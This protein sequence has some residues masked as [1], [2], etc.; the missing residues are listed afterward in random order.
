[1]TLAVDTPAVLLLAPLALLPALVLPFAAADHPSLT[2]VP[3]DRV[4]L[5]VDAGL[6]LV[7][8][9]ALA[10]LVLALAGLHRLAGSVEREGR[11]A[12]IVLLLDRSASMDNSF[13]GRRPGGDEESKSA[14]ARR[15]LL[16]F[17]E[18]RPHDRIG[19]AAFSTAPMPVLPVT[20]HHEALRAAVHA[21]D[22]PGLAHTDVGRGLALAFSMAEGATP[23]SAP[24][25]VLVSDGAAVI[26]RRVQD[27]LRD[28]AA[29]TPVHLYWLYLR[30]QGSRGIFGEPQQPGEDTPQA[31]PERHLHR[32]LGTLGIPYRAFEATGALAV[33][34]AIEAI[35]TLETRPIRYREPVPRRDL[36]GPAYATAAAG[37]LLLLLA[38]LAERRPRRAARP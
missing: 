12:E 37:V 8:V 23:G 30:T 34:T 2:E 20:D 3:P 35:A 18:R 6:R 7:A 11:G 21:I 26:D 10:S 1:M 32:F 19:V 27:A 4:S 28:A 25:V 5:A 38:K 9:V 13:A 17:L 14:A 29:R 31:M 15:L 33:E 16:Q 22:R 24:A 36:A